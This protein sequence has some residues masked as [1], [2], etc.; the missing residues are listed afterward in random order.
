MPGGT[1]C[2][3]A[4][5]KN[6]SKTAKEHGENLIFFSFPK[7]VKVQKEW[8]RKCYRKDKWNCANK[9]LCSRHFKPEDFED[10]LQARLLNIQPKKLKRDGK[11]T[12]FKQCVAN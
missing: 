3:V 2:S 8:I 11:F 9:R 5:C 6:N 1:V 4:I 7:D 10:E 12:F